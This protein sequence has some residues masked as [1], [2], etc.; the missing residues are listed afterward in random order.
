MKLFFR[1][2]LNPDIYEFST[3]LIMILIPKLQTNCGPK[4]VAQFKKKT[5][6]KLASFGFQRLTHI[7][8]S[9]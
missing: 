4:I 9:N 5:L 3:R 6:Q 7:I 1:V 2:L 8:Q